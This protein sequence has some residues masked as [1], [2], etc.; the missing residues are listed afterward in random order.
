MV[1]TGDAAPVCRCT[2]VNNTPTVAT[3]PTFL[4]DNRAVT[5]NMAAIYSDSTSVEVCNIVG[6][7]PLSDVPPCDNSAPQ[8]LAEAGEE[9]IDDTDLWFN[10]VKRVWLPVCV[11]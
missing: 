9:F 3:I 6:D 4:T 7:D 11:P 1:I 10:N 5:E 2:F 8:P